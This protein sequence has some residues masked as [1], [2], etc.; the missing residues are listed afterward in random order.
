MF[1]KTNRKKNLQTINVQHLD[2]ILTSL[3]PTGSFCHSVLS[4]NFL[5]RSLELFLQLET[6]LPLWRSRL[7]GIDTSC[8]RWLSSSPLTWLHLFLHLCCSA[9]VRNTKAKDET[10][11]FIRT[12]RPSLHLFFL[13]RRA[14]TLA[15][16][17]PR[18]PAAHTSPSCLCAALSSH[19]ALKE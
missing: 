14:W 13:L 16:F 1:K 7:D 18:S 19:Q 17:I 10:S 12:T 4:W 15:A 8:T 5:R 6:L 2:F 3:P 9:S 11:L